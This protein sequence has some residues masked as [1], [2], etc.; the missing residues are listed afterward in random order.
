VFHLILP[1]SLTTLL[2]FHHIGLAVADPDVTFRF[3]AL[4]GYTEGNMVYDPLQRVN[5][6]MRHHQIMPDF[7][8]IWPG[9]EPSPIDKMI[10]RHGTMMYHCCYET[11]RVDDALKIITDAGFDVAMVSPPKPA[12]LFGGREVSFHLIDKFGLIELLSASSAP[13]ASNK[14]P[15]PAG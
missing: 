3:L 13:T 14:S 11:D 12:L 8:V 4:Q 1:A 6:A 9:S 10:K 7:E 5:L 15:D 2:H